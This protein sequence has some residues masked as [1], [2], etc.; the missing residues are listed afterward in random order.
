MNACETYLKDTNSW[1]DH[2]LR[3]KQDSLSC[4][5]CKK[6]SQ[7]GV[8]YPFGYDDSNQMRVLSDHTECICYSTR[9]RC[10]SRCDSFKQLRKWSNRELSVLSIGLTSSSSLATGPSS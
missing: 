3:G 7:N 6:R 9:K 4:F 1:F 5:S 10:I 8:H 2:F